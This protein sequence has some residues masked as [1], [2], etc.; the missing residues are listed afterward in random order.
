MN[1]KLNKPFAANMAVD[2]DDVRAIKRGLNWLGYYTPYQKIGIS[3][4]P[5]QAVFEAIQEFQDD[6]G[7]SKTGTMKPD[8]DTENILSLEAEVTYSYSDEI[9]DPLSIRQTIRG[10]HR[11]HELPNSWLGG[12]ELFVTDLFLGRAYAVDSIWKTTLT[13]NIPLEEE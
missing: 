5:D 1:I 8:D 12:S 11:I 6:Q 2:E 9:T 10:H 3:P 13:G 4:Y 7:L